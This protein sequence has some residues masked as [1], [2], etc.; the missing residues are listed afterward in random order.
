MNH[1]TSSNS[2]L[3]IIATVIALLAL[4]LFAAVAVSLITTGTGIGI[5]EERSMEAFYIAEGG[6]EYI[7][8]NRRFPN[9][10]TQAATIPLGNGQLKVSTPAYLTANEAIGSVTIDVDSTSNFPNTGK[11]IIDSE[12]MTYTAIT[13]TT[14]TLSTAATQPHDSGSAAYPVTTVTADPGAGG[15]TIAVA[16]TTGFTAPAIIKIDN[17]DIYCPDIS[18]SPSQLT[19]CTRGYKGTTPAAHLVGINVFEYSFS[20]TGTSTS[21]LLAGSIQRVVRTK[22]TPSVSNNDMYWT[23]AA[24]KEWVNGSLVLRPSGTIAFG[25]ATSDAKSNVSSWNVSHTVSAGSNRILIVGVSCGGASSAYSTGVTYAG[26]NL[27]L[28]GGFN[29]PSVFIRTELWY[30]LNPPAGTADVTVTLNTN[31]SLVIGAISFTGVEQTNPFDTAPA[32]LYGTGNRANVIVPVITNGAWAVDVMA[33]KPTN[34]NQGTGQAERWNKNAGA[35]VRG[36]GSTKPISKSSVRDT[37]LWM[38]VF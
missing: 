33:L 23:L 20:S 32:F 29:H 22:M 7:I 1:K 14:F 36:A 34:A 19:N 12:V 8:K 2:G 5:Q 9:Y 30:L 28:L 18:A 26:Q 3:S 15:T 24:S 16:S 17:E 11:I 38:E 4:A 27:T 13:A 6:I 10:S 25:A 37:R 35:V 31:A 21:T